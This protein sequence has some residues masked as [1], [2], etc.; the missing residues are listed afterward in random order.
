MTVIDIFY[1]VII[2]SSLLGIMMLTLSYTVIQGITLVSSAI[3]NIPTY[4]PKSF[5]SGLLN[6]AKFL[7]TIAVILVITL[8]IFS[9][10]L[11]AFIKASPIGAVISIGWL[12]IYTGAAF[13]MSHYLI[14]AA[15]ISI[16][17]SLGANANL[18]FLFWANMPVILVFATVVDVVIAIVSYKKD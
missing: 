15:R 12:I 18:L 5:S 1:A 13:L 16:F 10:M 2:V 9:W 11:S 3:N 8:I 4:T 6:I 17:T 7:P 14:S